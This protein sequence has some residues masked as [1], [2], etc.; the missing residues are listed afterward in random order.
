MTFSPRRASQPDARILARGTIDEKTAEY[1]QGLLKLPHV[2]SRGVDALYQ[3]VKK[4]GKAYN[5]K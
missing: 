3:E 1:L 2:G 5:T 4:Q